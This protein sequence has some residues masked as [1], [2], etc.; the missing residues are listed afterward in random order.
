MKKILFILTVLPFVLFGCKNGN[1]NN[2]SKMNKDSVEVKTKT[3]DT[4][5]IV[6]VDE[7]ILDIQT[8]MGTIRVKLYKDTPLH[9]DNFMKL[10]SAK[11][12]DGI[13][14]HRV[15]K[16]FMIQAGDPYSK[17]ELNEDIFGTGGP[18]YTIPAE[19][20]HS[21]THKKGALAAA[22]KGDTANPQRESNGSQFY[23]VENAQTCSQLNGSYT[24]FGETISGL[25]VIDKISAVPTHKKDVP[26]TPVK[27]I[28]ITQVIEK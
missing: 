6:K 14:F 19:I 12:Y 28:S 4:M 23:L 8:T 17:N 5:A 15:I 13:A 2:A 27:I 10:V 11:F 24:V 1:N 25:D 7:P 21:H 9:R 18:G 16:D 20:L 22:R 3:V 26:D